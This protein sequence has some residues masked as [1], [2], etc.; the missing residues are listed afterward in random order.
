MV[1]KNSKKRIE[2]Q[3]PTEWKGKIYECN[4]WIPR[5]QKIQTSRRMPG[6]A[7]DCWQTLL[8]KTLYLPVLLYK[9]CARFSICACHLQYSLLVFQTV[10][11]SLSSRFYQRNGAPARALQQNRM[12]QG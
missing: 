6:E 7:S 2:N 10:C 11:Y 12:E 4:S 3:S 8:K 9:I 5:I 1:E